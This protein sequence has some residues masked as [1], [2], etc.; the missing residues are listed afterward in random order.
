MSCCSVLCC[1][2]PTARHSLYLLHLH[3]IKPSLYMLQVDLA[4][5]GDA[6]LAAKLPYL[7]RRL[8]AAHA[9]A[10]QLEEAEVALRE[11]LA[12]PLPPDERLPVLAQLADV[13]LREDSTEL[14]AKVQQRLQEKRREAAAHGSKVRVATG[15]D[16]DAAVMESIAAQGVCCQYVCRCAS[17]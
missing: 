4:H 12:H 9:A 7:V 16:G 15:W 8:G 13:Q 14:E 1:I 5:R 6:A 10:G 17:G 2:P 3:S 11:V